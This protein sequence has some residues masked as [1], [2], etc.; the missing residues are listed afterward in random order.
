MFLFNRKGVLKIV[1][2]REC[3]W[4]TFAKFAKDIEIKSVLTI[5]LSGS[6]M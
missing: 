4:S 5:G 1:R 2:R 3:L 6:E